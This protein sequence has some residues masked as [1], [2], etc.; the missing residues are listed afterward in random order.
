[1][2][3]KN[4]PRFLSGHLREDFILL[5]LHHRTSLFNIFDNIVTISIEYICSLDE[6]KLMKKYN[7]KQ[8]T[9][10]SLDNSE[11]KYQNCRKWHI[12]SCNEYII[13][14]INA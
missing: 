7:E 11:A 2:N 1:M 14:H 9:P 12:I 10:H 6:M 5:F 13:V 8:S 4:E 3:L